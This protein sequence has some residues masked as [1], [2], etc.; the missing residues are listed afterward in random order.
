MSDRSDESRVEV[1]PINLSN[2]G[3]MPTRRTVLKVGAAALGLGVV[4]VGRLRWPAPAGSQEA[5]S[6]TAD[7]CVLTPG[8]TEGP[9][10]LDD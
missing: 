10:Y 2:V 4:G 9:Y 3:A 7:V 8:L 6:P 5:A 1:G